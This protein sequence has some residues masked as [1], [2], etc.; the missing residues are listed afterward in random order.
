MSMPD[1][2][3]A[4]AIRVGALVTLLVLISVVVPVYLWVR[5][6]GVV[7]GPA[8]MGFAIIL[9]L[10]ITPVLS[11][12]MLRTRL[13]TYRLVEE[14]YRLAHMD[15]LTGLPNR[16]AFFEAARQL[17][18]RADQSGRIFFCG[19]ADIDNFKR[20]NDTYGH[21]TGDH[22]LREVAAVLN[23]RAP[24]D[25]VVA[26]LGG[27]EFALACIFEDETCAG[28]AF[29]GL[30]AAVASSAIQTV[31]ER[32]SVTISV[33]YCQGQA[34]LE[35]SSLLSRADHALYTAKRHGKN[36]ASSFAQPAVES[37]ANAA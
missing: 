21:D 19:I 5:T 7:D 27:E 17:Q 30:V 28:H 37:K 15:E 18:M 29:G 23:T 9:P 3:I 24:E 16:R 1:R 25:C 10:T 31:H 22:I 12:I 6:H 11:F 35:I 14:N 4:W 32:L 13:N 20:V 8:A 26:R 33:G 36:C 2:N 34:E